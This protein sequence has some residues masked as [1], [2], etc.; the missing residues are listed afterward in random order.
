M[1]I[2]CRCHGISG[3]CTTKTC[4]RRLSDFE[5][6]ASHLRKKYDKFVRVIQRQIGERV[7]L[8]PK[9]K[10]KYSPRDLIALQ[11]S[12]NF[13][14]R[15][16]KQGSLGTKGRRCSR[17]G[18]GQGSCNYMCCGRG[19]KRFKETKVERCNCRLKWCCTVIC[20][21]CTSVVNV[22]SCR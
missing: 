9:K 6:V 8:V 21:K 2:L 12:P 10:K 4:F 15:N 5:I 14:V 1:D 3:S 16:L 20:Q 22:N 17:K 11:K 7:T 13:C 18:R 19:Y